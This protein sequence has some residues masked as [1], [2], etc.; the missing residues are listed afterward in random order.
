MV[1]GHPIAKGKIHAGKNLRFVCV[2]VLF[3]FWCVFLLLLLFFDGQ[4]KAKS[5]MYAE[6]KLRKK[7]LGSAAKHSKVNVA[8][9]YRHS[10]TS[11]ANDLGF[12]NWSR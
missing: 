10:L 5:K 7:K 9:D 11:Q 2:C 12:S 6:K 3:V 4:F 8:L 1:D